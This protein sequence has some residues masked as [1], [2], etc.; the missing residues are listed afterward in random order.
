MWTPIQS[1]S[2]TWQESHIACP[3]LKCARYFWIFVALRLGKERLWVCKPY[4]VTLLDCSP[5]IRVVYGKPLSQ[6][7]TFLKKKGTTFKSKWTMCSKY[8][9]HLRFKS[10]LSWEGM[11]DRLKRMNFALSRCSCDRVPM[12]HLVPWVATHAR[13]KK[14]WNDFLKSS[15]NATMSISICKLSKTQHTKLTHGTR[16]L[17]MLTLECSTSSIWVAT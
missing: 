9:H 10:S 8:G 7:H 4:V 16:R 15:S 13:M 11:C 6:E 17:V 3:P 14:Y 5:I 12:Q 1:H 2:N